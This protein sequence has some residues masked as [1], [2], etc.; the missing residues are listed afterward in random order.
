M[1]IGIVM[2]IIKNQR[3]RKVS[4]DKYR[5]YESFRKS[6]RKAD[7]NDKDIYA[8]IEIG[9]CLMQRKRREKRVGY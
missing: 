3:E 9:E 7:V 6:E 2:I 1:I 4:R 5:P 8:C